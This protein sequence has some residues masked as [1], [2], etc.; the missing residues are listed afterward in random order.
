MCD[1]DRLV[2]TAESHAQ[3]AIPRAS[4][5]S[6]ERPM[7]HHKA[8]AEPVLDGFPRHYFREAS[9]VSFASLPKLDEEN[10]ELQVENTSQKVQGTSLP[11]SDK[12]SSPG[13]EGGKS[14]EAD[15]ALIITAA[16]QCVDATVFGQHMVIAS[17]INEEGPKFWHLHN[18]VLDVEM[19]QNIDVEYKKSLAEQNITFGGRNHAQLFCFY[20]FLVYVRK[21]STSITPCIIRVSSSNQCSVV[22]HVHL[23]DS[24]FSVFLPE[25]DPAATG[26]FSMYVV[27]DGVLEQR[28]ADMKLLRTIEVPKL[29]EDVPNLSSNAGK[30]RL[31]SYVVAVTE[32]QRYFIIVC[33]TVGGKS[34]RY[35]DVVDLKKNRYLKRSGLDSRFVWKLLEDGVYYLVQPAGSD[36]FELVTVRAVNEAAQSYDYCCITQSDLQTRSPDGQYGVELSADHSIHIWTTDVTVEP[37]ASSCEH[38]TQQMT[39]DQ[40]AFNTDHSNLTGVENAPTPEQLTPSLEQTA[41]SLEQ[42]SD[43]AAS[44]RDD[45]CPTVAQNTLTPE[46]LTTSLEQTAASLEQT[47]DQAA[48]N[49]D[50]GSP[51][52]TQNAP[53]PEQLT[54]SLEQTAAS[55]EQTSDQAASNTDHSAQTVDQNAPTAEHCCVLSGHVAEVTC[56]SWGSSDSLLFV[57]GSRDNTV[58]LWSLEGGGY[59]LCLFHVLGTIDNVH[60]DD[61]SRYVVAHC[62]YA[63]QRKRAII[64]K[65]TNVHRLF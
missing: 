37:A 54:P 46:Q 59:Q 22:A 57:S 44:N 20:D 9:C 15:E 7:S 35:L 65:L 49:R 56:V 33:P 45:G 28:S 58:R 61:T 53:T 50:D 14:V 11:V 47:S 19:T 16:E 32:D 18:G 36:N 13:E 31:L 6:N 12:C 27:R 8:T 60:F 10:D 40:A 25:P 30:K 63:P 5:S 41:T 34:G 23:P 2:K 24:Y 62:S 52:V 42:T 48:S 1:T 17:H 21:R 4:S 64:L 29:T 43:Q 3:R 55:L 39:S 51:T 26:P 38:N